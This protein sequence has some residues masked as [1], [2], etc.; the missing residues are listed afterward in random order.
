MQFAKN[1]LSAA[2]GMR[3][4]S[5]TVP[6]PIVHCGRLEWEQKSNLRRES[7][8]KV[9]KKLLLSDFEY[10]PIGEIE[11]QIK[12]VELALREL[13]RDYFIKRQEYRDYARIFYE[14][15]NAFMEQL[16]WLKSHLT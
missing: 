11:K 4:K 6:A 13:Q 7:M 9:G 2:D 5:E 8:E 14:K 16:K 3:R 10:Q 12:T 1:A 15:R